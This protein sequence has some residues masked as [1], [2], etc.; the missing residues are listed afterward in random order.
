M[1][2]GV[3][4]PCLDGLGQCGEHQ[5]LRWMTRKTNRRGV[6]PLEYERLVR[7]ATDRRPA[8]NGQRLRHLIDGG[9]LEKIDIGETFGFKVLV[10]C[11]CQEIFP[12]IFSARPAGGSEA[13]IPLRSNGV[14]ASQERP[15]LSDGSVRPQKSNGPPS[16]LN[17]V[18]LAKDIFPQLVALNPLQ[19]NWHAL[20]ANLKRW[21]E[22]Y[23]ID[24]PLVFQMME[25]FAQHPE[26]CQRSRNN[27]WQVFLSRRDQLLGLVRHQQQRSAMWSERRTPR[28]YS[29]A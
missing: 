27:P 16:A 21:P 13:M 24:F 5:L 19:N 26:C 15:D 23:G 29:W 6:V 14:I 1:G 2:D 25:E 10:P 9:Y 7:R 22:R 28:A 3:V 20:A 18:T 11:G 12:L 17:S 4:P 8:Q